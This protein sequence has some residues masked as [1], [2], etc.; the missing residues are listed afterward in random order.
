V[1]SAAPNL[2]LPPWLL[3]IVA[4]VVAVFTAQR[5]PLRLLFLDLA[6]VMVPGGWNVA[7]ALVN[8]TDLVLA[9]FGILLLR[10]PR[11]ARGRRSTGP[12][13]PHLRLWIMLGVL[14]SLAYLHAPQNHENLTDPLRLVYQLYR[15][16]WKP[17]LYY[18]IC[19]GLLGDRR[20]LAQVVLCLLIV[21]DLASVQG[22][23]QGF[24]GDRASGPFIGTNA[25]GGALVAPL[26]LASLFLVRGVPGS[27]MFYV[28]S[29][30]LMGRALI[31]S[32][33][34]G[35]LVATFAGALLCAFYLLRTARGRRE[36]MRT[37]A[38]GVLLLIGL[39]AVRP[40]A[41]DGP[42]VQRL[43]SVTGGTQVGNFQ[44][45]LAKR[46]P[47]FLEIVKAN[48]LFGVGTDVDSTLGTDMN[49]P[50]NGYLALSV[51]HGVPAAVV[52]VAFAVF[53]VRAGLRTF[54]RAPDLWERTFG[55]AT[56]AGML[57]ILIHNVVDATLMMPFVANLFWLLA[58]ATAT[59]E[60]RQAPPAPAR[61]T[62]LAP[63]VAR[64]R[65]RGRV[66]ARPV[67]HSG[68]RR[69]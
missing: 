60:R 12:K 3:P 66:P 5:A 31:F 53:T 46:W 26:L 32:T 51:T 10:R 44:W 54:R 19:V 13:V 27:R 67:R 55:L 57:G 61:E 35:A 18:P 50:H 37:A 15:Y 40:D 43:V 17:I 58:A 23:I 49:T 4:L 47:H 29:V 21:A 62:A 33:S 68:G 65:V 14:Q 64:G 39:F 1:E 9:G 11:G 69:A 7:G 36:V 25:L 45:R 8:P 41:L 63:T 2:L 30:L 6:F 48:P 34:R 38:A 22:I 20:R 16:C 52:F 59:A 24:E 56:A 28:V 42:N